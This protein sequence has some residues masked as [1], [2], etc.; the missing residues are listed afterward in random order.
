[1]GR[2]KRSA[3][4]SVDEAGVKFDPSWS[5][6]GLGKRYQWA[7][8]DE[9]GVRDYAASS[10]RRFLAEVRRNWKAKGFPTSSG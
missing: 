3:E 8:T 9:S 10:A 7:E 5:Y 1:M 2:S 6:T 4:V